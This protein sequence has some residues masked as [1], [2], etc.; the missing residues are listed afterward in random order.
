MGPKLGGLLP[1]T[2]DWGRLTTAHQGRA[3]GLQA[4][5]SPSA[6]LT[7][8]RQHPG[9]QEAGRRTLINIEAAALFLC[10]KGYQ[11]IQPAYQLTSRSSFVLSPAH[12]YERWPQTSS[13]LRRALIITYVSQ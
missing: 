2:A 10:Q 12:V 1:G 13:R 6:S 3:D 9:F 8:S 4:V 11:H 5:P 7:L